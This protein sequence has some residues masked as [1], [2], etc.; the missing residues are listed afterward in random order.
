MTDKKE[1]V[2]VR[3]EQDGMVL[4]CVRVLRTTDAIDTRNAGISLVSSVWHRKHWTMRRH[5]LGAFLGGGAALLAVLPL[6]SAFEAH[7]INVTAQIESPAEC[8]ARGLHYWSSNEGCIRGEGLSPWASNVNALSMNYSGVFGTH[9]EDQVCRDLWLPNCRE[10][11]RMDLMGCFARAHT[12][13]LE[14]NVVSGHLDPAALLAGADTGGGTF[15]DLGLSNEST[16][17]EAIDALEQILSDPGASLLQLHDAMDVAERIISFYERKNPFAPKCVYDPIDVPYCTWNSKEFEQNEKEGRRESTLDASQAASGNGAM[18]D[19]QIAADH[20]TGSA[21]TS[22]AS[23]VAEPDI[24]CCTASSSVEAQTSSEQTP[25]EL[26]TETVT[27]SSTRATNTEDTERTRTT[28][29]AAARDQSENR[30][31]VIDTLIGTSTPATTDS[32]TTQ[33]AVLTAI[34]TD[35]GV[36]G[37]SGTSTPVASL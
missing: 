9:A 12:L 20:A 7:V 19:G 2:I 1:C 14:L 22:T 33:E 34:S 37:E 24:T 4:R 27:A 11:D 29:A 13:A 6:F 25:S 26:Q 31:G 18:A 36:T 15:G 17:D 21:A 30:A 5:G 16:I 8:D 3:K 32:S 23:D 10:E 35:E 28:D